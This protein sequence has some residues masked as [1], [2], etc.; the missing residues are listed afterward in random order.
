MTRARVVT[1]ALTAA[2][3]AFLGALLVVQ[4]GRLGAPTVALLIGW[5]ALVVTAIAGARAL[6]ALDGAAA[7]PAQDA[8]LRD[9]AGRLRARLAD[10]AEDG[11][12]G[13][14]SAEEVTDEDRRLRARL[15]EITRSLAGGAGFEEEIEREVA[16]RLAPSESSPICPGCGTRN[17]GDASFCKRCGARLEAG[18]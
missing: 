18:S 14:V 12:D 6:A 10:L 5:G 17:D 8:R 1:F 3:A 9:E 7:A 2:S 11:R 4:R 13:V 16:R 15:E